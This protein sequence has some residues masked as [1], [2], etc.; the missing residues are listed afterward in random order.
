MTTR[1]TKDERRFLLIAGA[2][3][4]FLSLAFLPRTYLI[5]DEGSYLALA[6]TLE[7]GHLH[8]DL[9]G[10]TCNGAWFDDDGHQVAKHPPGNALFLMPFLWFGVRATFLAAPLAH[11]AGFVLAARLFR[12]LGR[13]PRLAVL[14]L[15]HPTCVLFARTVMSDVLAATC[16]LLAL[17]EIARERA[18]ARAGLGLGLLLLVRPGEALV[19]VAI[20]VVA[21]VHA[22][23]RGRRP[24][25]VRS[26]LGLAAGAAPAV[27]VLLG[28]QALTTGNPFV[29]AYERAGYGSSLFALEHFPKN[30]A[31]YLLFLT[32]MPPLLLVAWI[33]DRPRRAIVLAPVL[34][35]LV[36]YGF[37]GFLDTGRNGP[38]APVRGLRFHL[39][40]LALLLSSYAGWLERFFPG[41]KA[42]ARLPWVVLAA[43]LVPAGAIIALHERRI[44]A[45]AE[46]RD[47]FYARIPDG[48]VVF[49][50][51]GA[52]KLHQ[53]LWGGRREV[54]EWGYEVDRERPTFIALLVDDQAERT[55]LHENYVALIASYLNVRCERTPP[56]RSGVEEL[57][58][59]RVLP[60]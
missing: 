48:S 18:S 11:L 20:G 27:L 4:L 52:I 42:R 60:N 44:A 46:L 10:V 34:A 59:Y 49:V 21:L 47:A 19:A 53:T 29:L 54:R 7:R 30:A 41:E 33:G 3:F 12:A 5:S 6:T 28:Y 22:W 25:L 32:V 31:M 39:P 24:E 37:Y 14:Y 50:D 45:R 55:E 40:V 51:D 26:A 38:D 16:A 15:F 17:S 58:I 2:I 1:M 36:F 8:P 57:R 43:L 9:A 35:S 23:K 56:V 13:D